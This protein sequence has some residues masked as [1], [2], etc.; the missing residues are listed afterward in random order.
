M[1]AYGQGGLIHDIFEGLEQKVLSGMIYVVG[2]IGFITGFA[3]GLKILGY[4][5]KERSQE[6]LLQDKSL[7]M[8]Y[9]LLAWGIAGLTSFCAIHAYKI[10]F[11]G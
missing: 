8:T 6:D 1:C 9:G 7:R 3:L 10:Y 2:I 4:L 5:L 11:L